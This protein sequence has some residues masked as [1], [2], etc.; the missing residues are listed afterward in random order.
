MM[1][2][3]HK[4]VSIPLKNGKENIKPFNLR[5]GKVFR[6]TGGREGLLDSH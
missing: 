5:G 3:S 1:D 2:K 6:R 4:L